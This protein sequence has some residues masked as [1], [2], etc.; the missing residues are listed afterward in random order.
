MICN[1]Q[2]GF[3]KMHHYFDVGRLSNRA[4]TAERANGIFVLSTL[5]AE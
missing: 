5:I 4:R 1:F 3:M 2:Y